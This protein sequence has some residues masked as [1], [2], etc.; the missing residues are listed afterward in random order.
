MPITRSGRSSINS[1][2]ITAPRG[3]SVGKSIA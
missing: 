2:A 1:S 3:A